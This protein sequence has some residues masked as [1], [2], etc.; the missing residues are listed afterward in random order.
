MVVA[1]FVDAEPSRVEEV[2][3]TGRVHCIQ[4]HGEESPELC[5]SFGVPFLKTVRVSDLD[6]AKARIDPFAGSSTILL[7]THVKGQVGGTGKTFDW[8]IAAQLAAIISKSHS[9]CRRPEP[10]GT[11]V[12]PFP[13][14]LLLALIFAV[15]SNLRQGLRILAS[16][17][18]FS[19]LYRRQMPVRLQRI[20]D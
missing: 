2:L 18:N 12:T 5:R 13:E 6:E 19:W 7:D 1:L 3:A 9:T 15:A 17:R 14:Y 16:C 20:E 10:F 11:S 8:N 4:F